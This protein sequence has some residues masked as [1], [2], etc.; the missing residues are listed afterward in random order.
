[1]HKIERKVMLKTMSGGS[2]TSFNMVA[3]MVPGSP[4]QPTFYLI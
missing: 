4:Q 1:M 2:Q 3:N